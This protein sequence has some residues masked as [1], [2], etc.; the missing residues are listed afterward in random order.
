MIHKPSLGSLDVPQK[1][2]GPIGSAVLT[3]IGYKQTNRQTN[4][5]AKFIYRWIFYLINFTKTKIQG[6][7]RVSWLDLVTGSSQG[8]FL[9]VW[10]HK[11]LPKKN[12]MF[13]DDLN[14]FN[15]VFYKNAKWFGKERE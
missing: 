11:G 10:N 2:L 12:D 1:N 9:S 8:V 6:E 13:K 15:I 4:R 5:Q 14:I 3:F 7:F